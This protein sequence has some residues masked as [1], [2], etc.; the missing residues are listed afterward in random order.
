MRNGKVCGILGGWTAVGI[1]ERERSNINCLTETSVS[2]RQ[3]ATV[4]LYKTPYR[5]QKFGGGVIMANPVQDEGQATQEPSL[6]PDEA[7]A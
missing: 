5:M 3:I 2:G 1:E 6:R 4:G 7:L